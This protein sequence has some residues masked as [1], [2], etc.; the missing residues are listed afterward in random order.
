MKLRIQRFNIAKRF[1][2]TISRG[3]SVGSENVLVTIEHEGIEGIG[4]MAPTSG[5]Q[6]A[7][8]AASAVPQLE[9]WAGLLSDLTPWDLQRIERVLDVQDGERAAYCALDCALHDWQG[10]QLGIPLWKMFG[11]DRTEIPPI[12]VTI[13]INPPDVIGERVPEILARTKARFLKIKL[14]NP[15]GIAR[16]QESFIAAQEAAMYYMQGTD[17]HVGWRVDANGGWNVA[18]ARVMLQWLAERNVE[19]VEQP[20]P[21][22]QEADLPALFHDRP[23]PLY[24]DESVCIA[25]DVP[26]LANC[27][28]GVNLK[29]M[30]CG[31]IR[32]AV[33]IIHADRKSVV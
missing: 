30:K 14:G 7:E 12:S 1:P 28:D 13:G 6:V 9:R 5:G 3:T 25:Q 23:L 10:K 27:V 21:R 22:G 4:E 24:V 31:G 11:L 26:M 29:L 15:A 17:G 18:D 19:F 2:L 16:D 8:T 32:E 33:R 20:L